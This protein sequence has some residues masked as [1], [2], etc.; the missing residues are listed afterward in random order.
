[1]E[2]NKMANKTK[3]KNGQPK[4]DTTVTEVEEANIE[5][6]EHDAS[7]ARIMANNVLK[8]K[9]GLEAQEQQLQEMRQQMEQM[10]LRYVEAQK[11]KERSNG[12]FEGNIQLSVE[13]FNSF[14][15]KYD[16]KEGGQYGIDWTIDADKG[17][18]VLLTEMMKG[19][20]QS[21]ETD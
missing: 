4:V 17:T 21:S 8:Q 12:A 1:M 2:G 5:L 6:D 20:N 16:L 3:P 11:Q 10:Q 7:N 9:T 18:I 14:V 15:N 19:V 13:F